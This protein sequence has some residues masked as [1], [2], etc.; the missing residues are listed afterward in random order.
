LLKSHSSGEPVT[1][2]AT[3]ATSGLTVRV[4]GEQ[5]PRLV[6]EECHGY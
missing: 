1:A 2:Y 4:L 6:K 3:E 5:Q